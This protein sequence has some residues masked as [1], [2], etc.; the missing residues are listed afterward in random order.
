MPFTDAAP[1]PL[2]PAML[3]GAGNRCPACGRTPLFRGWLRVNACCAACGAPLGRARADDAPPYFVI[4]LTGHVVVGCML[5]L[6]QARHPPIWVHVAIFLPM[7]L[8]M[9]LA[10]LRPVKGATV[11]LMLHMGMLR[12]PGDDP[13]DPV[14]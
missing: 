9:A 8:L 7:T 11:G 4:F 10:L 2:L 13:D 12:D 1:P 3:R 6:E 14:P 5:W